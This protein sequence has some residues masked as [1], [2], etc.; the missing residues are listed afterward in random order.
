MAAA[1]LALNCS[2]ATTAYSTSPSLTPACLAYSYTCCFCSSSA[3]GVKFG[4]CQN[5]IFLAR[6]AALL[7]TIHH[8]ALTAAAATPA[9]F[10]ACRRVILGGGPEMAPTPPTVRGAPG[11]PCRP[12]ISRPAGSLTIQLS[13][14]AA[15]REAFHDPALEDQ[16]QDQGR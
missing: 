10:S 16:V 8:G 4:T 13:F 3:S 5:T 11:N 7:P 12:S 15:Q 2:L 1:S 9:V 6:W 14:H